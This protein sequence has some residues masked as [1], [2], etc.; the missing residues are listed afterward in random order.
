M[1]IHLFIS[2]TVITSASIFISQQHFESQ[3]VLQALQKT[4]ST[5]WMTQTG[6]STDFLLPVPS[7]P[8]P[9]QPHAHPDLSA[10]VKA[11]C[12]E[13][14]LMDTTFSITSSKRGS[15]CTL[16]WE[17]G[18]LQQINRINSLPLMATPKTYK[19]IHLR[20]P[21]ILRQGKPNCPDSFQ[22]HY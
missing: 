11:V 5:L 22:P 18:S 20:V 14:Q 19:F 1:C 21:L 4:L 12:R 8:H 13:P 2:L 7:C 10:K 3:A 9:F 6:V 15:D 16:T 17:T